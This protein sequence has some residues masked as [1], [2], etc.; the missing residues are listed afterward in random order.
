[1]AIQDGKVITP[2]AYEMAN[3]RAKHVIIAMS[4][5]IPGLT[6]GHLIIEPVPCKAL[7]FEDQSTKERSRAAKQVQERT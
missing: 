4:N 5:L 7:Y 2:L 6:L 3:E 1:M